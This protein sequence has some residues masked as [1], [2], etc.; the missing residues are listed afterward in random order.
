MSITSAMYTGISGLNANGEAISVV[1]NNLANTNTI[2]FK[3]GRMLFSDVLS[4][5]LNNTS[6]VG[7]GVQIQ[8]VQNLFGQGT[9]ETTQSATD[10]GIQ[11]DSFFVVRQPG[12]SQFYTRAG[13]FNFDNNKIMVNPDGYQVQGFGINQATGLNNGIL[14]N[15]DLTNFASLAPKMTSNV[16]TVLNLD[17]TQTIPGGVAMDVD[18]TGTLTN[19][20]FVAGTTAGPVNTVVYD[21]AGNPHTA[22]INFTQTATNQWSWSADVAGATAPLTGTLDLTGPGNTFAG[23][24]QSSPTMVLNGAA[25]S[26]TIDMSLMTGAAASAPTVTASVPPFTTLTPFNA[27]NATAT[28]NF[29]NSM[30]VYDSQGN[31]HSINVYYTKTGP[32][33]WDWHALTPGATAGFQIDGTL[34]FNGAGVL[35]AATVTAVD[36]VPAGP[37]TTQNITFAGGVSAP[38]PI[39][40]DFGVNATTQYASASNV[41]S[42]SQ[43]G[44]IQ[45][46]L[47]SVTVDKQGFVIGSYSNSQS[48]KLAQV[49]LANFASTTGLS[50]VGSTLFEA[51]PASGL[52]LISNASSPGVGTVLS[53]S[54]EQS[55]VDMATEFVKLIQ[56][57]RA[58][59]ANSKTITTA[60][61]MTQEVLNLKR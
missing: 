16:K 36:G 48:Q 28:S 35:T 7:H 23:S 2:G 54:L 46:S 32:N 49:A 42:I 50:K 39:T 38:Q 47:S 21:N 17:S 4:S 45:G 8:A 40:F 37:S 19:A 11:G 30:T 43:D 52:A 56:Y 31:A 44:Y 22:T 58:Y 51:T 57:Q 34:A 27:A 33:T 20:A 14:G 3:T 29:T 1:G 10:L 59:S 26:V 24:T 13:A 41:N 25:E 9:F 15:I 5:N 6:Q 60:D 18:V 53:N 61:E 12:G 55:N